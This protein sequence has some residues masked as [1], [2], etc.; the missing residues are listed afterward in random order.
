M[1]TNNYSN[2]VV[3]EKKRK[4]IIRYINMKLASMGQPIYEGESNDLQEGMTEQEFVNLAESLLNNYKEKM[5]LLSMEIINPADKR[6]QN[7]INRY[8]NDLEYS[9]P[10]RIPFDSFVLDKAGIGREVS[11][12]PNSN[13]F[14]NKL[15]KSYRIAQGV[16]HNPLHD[17]RT[18]KD[19]FHIVKG[20]LPVPPDKKEVPKLAFAHMLHSALT[21]P[22]EYM[23]LPFT[24][25]QKN[26]AH[27]WTSLLLRPTVS[28]EVPG[29]M[30]RKTME[31]RFFA[32]ASLVS[33]LDFVESI[34]GNAGDPYLFKND[35]G[36]DIE[37]W[38]GHTGCVI[39]AP[40]LLELKKSEI[41]LP[42][43]EDATE[44]QRKDG[45]CWKD[46]NELYNEGVA[47]KVTCRDESG[48]VI[49][50]IADNYFGY[51]KKEVKTQISYAANMLGLSEEEHAGGTLA[52]SRRNV[53]NR[54]SASELIKN[55][56]GKFSF[57]EVKKQFAHMMDIL[58]ENYGV[59][60]LHSNVIYLP[61]NAE[62]TLNDSRI[63]WD[64]KGKKTGIKL[65]RNHFYVLPSGQKVHMEKHPFAPNWYLVLT[66]AE[67]SF[68]HK[69]STVSGGGKSEISKSLLNAINYGTFYIDNKETDFAKVD[70]II[71][72]DYSHRWKNS[73]DKKE[74][75]RTILGPDRTLGSVIKLLTP[76]DGYTDEYNTFIKS[77]PDQVKALLFLIKKVSQN[78]VIGTD[79][80]SLFSIDTVNG[81]MGHS[82]MHDN[83]K[84]N[85]SYLRVGFAQDKSWYMHSLRP[86]FIA[87]AKVQMEDDISATIT[88]PANLLEYLHPDQKNLS[89]K[90]V[91]NCEK[92][93]F[94]RPDEAIHRGYDK[95]AE[96]DLSQQNNFTTNYEPLS[97]DDGKEIIEDAIHFD[98]YT[99]PIKTLI[100]RGAADKN[101]NFFITP[102]HLR[103]LDNNTR[104]GNPRYLQTNPDFSNPVDGY[105][106]KVGIRLFRKIPLDKPVNFPVTNILAGRK[107]N[108]ADI[109]A[110]LRSLSVYNPIHYQEYPELFMDFICS[111]TGKSPSTTGAGSEGALTKGPFN[112][113]VAT[114]DLNNALLSYI[115]TGYDGFSTSAGYVGP[116]NRFDHDIS[117]L[118][119]E[120]WCRMDSEEK[121]PT[122][123]IREGLL[124]KVDDFEFKGQKVLASR[125]GYRITRSFIFKHLGRI[126]EEPMGVFSDEV[127]RPELQDMEEFVDGVNNIVEAQQKS[128]MMYIED[129]SVESAIP[130]LQ[131]L[132]HVMAHGD[133]KGMELSNPELRKMFTREY[134]VASDWY[135]ERLS[136]KQQ[137]DTKH[138]QA[139]IDYITAFKDKKVNQSIIEELRIDEKLV[140]A[141]KELTHVKSDSY[142]KHLE[143]TIGLDNIFK[144][145]M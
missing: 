87:A 145:K 97:P 83:R 18:T 88:V 3:T 102:S 79:W 12:P 37:H 137:R 124:E 130:P 98:K 55:F 49:T 118:I 103:K 7:F 75:N 66:F 52:F 104:S 71:A 120:L 14:E 94:Q 89:V 44:R 8:L 100:I 95:Q 48:V 85:T 54:F 81:R 110:G 139:Q 35:S 10:L 62:F 125:L 122:R 73:S 36:L 16:L 126:F 127:L 134:V 132:I 109:K 69:P 123:L 82:L 21:P 27:L 53:G 46:K 57:E 47:F 38:S 128:A 28:P 119:P 112:M 144:R 138:W 107:N 108:P 116:K 22:E 42:N 140:F 50:L 34:F 6:I 17:R 40:Q 131:V 91:E 76:Y 78:Q 11:L 43:W 9:L 86:D 136:L 84:I 74:V 30:P 2:Q 80:R 61:E 59:D 115:L 20:G 67:G 45:M 39:L 68:L 51:S 60:K 41:G 63:S 101:G 19:S 23:I 106:A 96:E 33:N 26:K 77:I 143:G 111:L 65:L 90:L 64:Y 135:K 113:L 13:K 105:L 121:K 56:E 99:D 72:Y 133:F 15:I 93:F 129:G 58:P 114:T 142:L 25:A 117:I 4:D 92:L 24:S 1:S 5:R 32:P 29:F 141:Q 70:E 31:I